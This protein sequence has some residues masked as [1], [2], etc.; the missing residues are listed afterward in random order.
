MRLVRQSTNV[1]LND[2]E[3]PGPRKAQVDGRTWHRFMDYLYV[4][5]PPA[6]MEPDL[7][8]EV[9]EARYARR[10][11]V[12][13]WTLHTAVQAAMVGLVRE[14]GLAPKRVLDFG[15]GSGVG[16]ETLRAMLGAE[17][18]G[19][20]MSLATLVAAG[21]RNVVL[22]APEG[23]L[24]FATGSFDLVHALFVMHF[25]VPEAM[26]RELMGVLAPGGWLVA[27]CY[28]DGVGAYRERMLAAG[29]CLQTS[30]VVEGLN[31]HVADLW[32]TGAAAS[33]GSSTRP[34][35]QAK[36]RS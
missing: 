16:A 11:Q 9:C 20:D 6:L 35:S 33:H 36:T 18:V 34:T 17:V 22:V 21:H 27:N 4:P 8:R 24:P 15:T 29:W 1:L 19:C 14:S 12:I 31:D 28:G 3:V 26:L 7:V 10:D 25:P 13:D 32:F 23:P 2:G 30:Q 5:V